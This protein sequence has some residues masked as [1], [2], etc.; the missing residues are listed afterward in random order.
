MNCTPP[1]AEPPLPPR[2]RR[3]ALLLA[4]ILVAHVG[5]AL[6]MLVTLPLWGAV[7]D[8]PLHF[9]YA[10]YIAVTGHLPQIGVGISLDPRYYY[11]APSAGEAAH[12][13]PAYY[14]LGSLVYRLFASA[15]LEAQN[16][17]LRALSLVLSVVA[18]VLLYLALRELL[19]RQPWLRLGIVALVAVFPHFLL[20]SSVIYLEAFGAVA[21]MGAVW[22]LAR[23]YRD[24][25][26]PWPLVG[27]GGFV[28]LMALTK[29]TILPL[30]LGF[31]ATAVILICQ[32][33]PPIKRGLAHGAAF[34]V[35]AAA[36]AGWW[37]VRNVVVYGQPC[38]TSLVPGELPT[39]IHVA[40]GPPDMLTLLF[41]P[42]GRFYYWL[43]ITGA[44]HYFWGP[45]DWLPPGI[46]PGMFAVA[47]LTW[48]LTPVGLWLGRR[49]RDGE[50][51]AVWAGF[52]VPFSAALCLLAFVHLR[53][54]VTTCI[55]AN[56]EFGK[57]IMPVLGLLV[58]LFSE[59]LR[60]LAGARW[61]AAILLAF[62]L[63]FVL[64]DVIALHH[65]ATVLIPA[66]APTFLHP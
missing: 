48:I 35:S 3:E 11:L 66:H 22:M 42:E 4:L 14:F 31:T 44:F 23:Y 2:P 52:V 27:A 53:W 50:L 25:S 19:P 13:P 21:A 62:V 20:M 46:R 12:H 16:Y 54:A 30:A 49:R 58:W 33:R 57:F 15:S 24:R 17:A 26:S 8:E 28:G 45:D 6:W 18:L 1:D 9:G 59:G 51:G 47:A 7:L 29:M 55:Q 37:Y 63:F 10:K 39:T 38:P 65:I 41:V 34:A 61:A 43:V 56:A 64:W 60:C 36:V 40:G 32:A 5:L